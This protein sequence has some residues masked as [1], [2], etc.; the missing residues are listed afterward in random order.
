MTSAQCHGMG[1]AVLTS[2]MKN[3]NSYPKH[4]FEDVIIGDGA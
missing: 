4:F 2:H 1:L 3:P